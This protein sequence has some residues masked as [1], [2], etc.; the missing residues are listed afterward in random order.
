MISRSPR[1]LWLHFSICAWWYAINQ[2][3]H[4]LAA[5]WPIAS[6]Y[7]FYTRID[8]EYIFDIMLDGR[9]D[10]FSMIRLSSRALACRRQHNYWMLHA[11]CTASITAVFSFHIFM[12]RAPE[13]CA[14]RWF[15]SI[16][17]FTYIEFLH[18]PV[19]WYFQRLTKCRTP[20]SV[21]PFN[22]GGIDII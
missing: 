10:W 15:S 21:S 22:F 8:D 4:A 19:A 20:T 3:I 1:T 11:A 9:I 17:A 2:C 16:D 18:L 14:R 13:R 12:E 7:K 6:L 5:K